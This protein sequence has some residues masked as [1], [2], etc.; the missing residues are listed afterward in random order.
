M[1]KKK[2]SS[3]KSQEQR[4][5]EKEYKRVRKNLQ[6]RLYRQKEKGI[7]VTTQVI[8]P[9]PKKITQASINRLNKITSQDIISKSEKIF[10]ED[11]PEQET[12]EPQESEELDE[13]FDYGQEHDENPQDIY[14]AVIDK[15]RRSLTAGPRA[16]EYHLF[17]VED[18]LEGQIATYGE[19]VVARHLFSVMEQ[20]DM[21]IEEAKATSDQD[22]LETLANDMI[23]LIAVESMNIFDSAENEIDSDWSV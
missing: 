6:N 19:E 22:V 23:N 15:Y 12:I 9:I 2:R 11:E 5:L 17:Q 1:A 13:S 20:L 10:R 3:R 8:P 18:F 21:L 14:R 7:H 4:R 16:S